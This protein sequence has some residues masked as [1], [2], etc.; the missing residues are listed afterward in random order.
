[1]NINKKLDRVKQWAGEKMGAESKTSVSDEFRIL[2][3]EMNLRHDGM[4][5]LQKSMTGYVKSL[6]KRSEVDDGEKILPGGHLGQTMMNHGEDF[7][8]DSDFG[9][10]LISMGRS[11][12][13]IARM[14]ETY[15]AQA[16]TSWLESLERSLAQMKE[17]QAARKKLETR[18]LAYDA[19]LSKMQKAKKEDF[20][21]EEELRS[22]KIKY[23]ETSE[24]VMRRMQDIKEAEADSVADLGTFLDAE[25]DY[26]DKCRDELL[27]LKNDWP[28]GATPGSQ[29]DHGR[30][31]RSRSNTAHSYNDRYTMHEEPEPELPRPAIRSNG[32]VA[33]STR[34]DRLDAPREFPVSPESPGRPNYGRAQTFEGPRSIGRTGTPVNGMRKT[35]IPEDP[36]MLR[37]QLRPPNRINTGNNLFSDPSDVSTVDSNS[38]DHSYRERSVSPATSHDSYVSRSAT[39]PTPVTGGRKGPPPPPPARGKKPPP[40]PPMKRADMSSS[41]VNRY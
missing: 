12:E 3:V 4:E 40:P 36:G 25:L 32:R 35:L 24:D 16:T 9:N 10:C 34:L 22:Q 11:N 19:S 30:L 37:A 28:A 14:Q 20:R 15:V 41:S 13:R 6:S 21:V 2:E 29:R 31:P 1:M 5:R 17:Y 7:E 38:P 33:S 26:Y 27:R 23:E 18:R 8:P 39:F